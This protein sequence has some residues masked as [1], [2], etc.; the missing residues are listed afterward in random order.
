[1]LNQDDNG[2]RRSART[3]GL[4]PPSPPSDP[5]L[6]LLSDGHRTPTP[7][8]E[9][10]NTPQDNNANIDQNDNLLSFDP[11]IDTNSNDDGSTSH[12]LSSTCS[13]LMDSYWQPHITNPTKFL[14]LI[15]R[16]KFFT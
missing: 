2:R 4:P 1:M 15:L 14:V 8:P 10:P 5:P 13:A 11:Y 16:E 12:L 6:D 3:Q 7:A 9:P